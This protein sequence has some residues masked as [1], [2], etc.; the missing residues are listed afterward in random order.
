MLLCLLPVFVCT[1]KQ[2]RFKQTG[3]G[4]LFGSDAWH[5]GLYFM[6]NDIHTSWQ[7]MGIHANRIPTCEDKCQV[8]LVR[9]TACLRQSCMV[10]FSTH[11]HFFDMQQTRMHRNQCIIALK[12]CMPKQRMHS[13]RCW[14]D[15][16]GSRTRFPFGSTAKKWLQRHDIVIQLRAVVGMQRSY[17]IILQWSCSTLLCDDGTDTEQIH[18]ISGAASPSRVHRTFA[19]HNSFLALMPPGTDQ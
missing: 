9:I 16:P 7:G 10:A 11:R 17:T 3:L 6:D 2:R 18:T 13:F 19:P 1:Q 12:H 4:N 8:F 5:L 15:P 14:V